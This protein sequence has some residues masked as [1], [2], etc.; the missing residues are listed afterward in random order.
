MIF[1][2]PS[3]GP[4]PKPARAIPD[5]SAPRDRSRTARQSVAAW[6]PTIL[7]A[8]GLKV[9]E[10]SSGE[11]IDLVRR[12]NQAVTQARARLEVLAAELGGC[13]DVGERLELARIRYFEYRVARDVGHLAVLLTRP[14]ATLLRASTPPVEEALAL[15]ERDALVLGGRLRRAYGRSS[16]SLSRD[17]GALVET[18]AMLV[19]WCRE[20]EELCWRCGVPVPD[21]LGAEKA[22]LYRVLDVGRHLS[23]VADTALVS[24]MEGDITRFEEA[25]TNAREAQCRWSAGSLADLHAFDDDRAFW[26]AMT[27]AFAGAPI[28][29]GGPLLESLWRQLDDR[30][31]GVLRCSRKVVDAHGDGDVCWSRSFFAQLHCAPVV[32]LALD[33]LHVVLAAA[34]GGPGTSSEI[35]Y[36]E[37]TGDQPTPLAALLTRVAEAERRRR[38]TELLRNDQLS[39]DREFRREQFGGY[40]PL[41][42]AGS[43]LAGNFL[44]NF[45]AFLARNWRC[46]TGAGGGW[47]RRRGW[48]TSCSTPRGSTS[49]PCVRSS[50]TSGRTASIRRSGPPRCWRTPAAPIRTRR[51]S[52]GEPYVRGCSTRC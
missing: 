23:D 21:G 30:R 24:T 41:V 5:E 36:H 39:A 28:V 20:I 16:T 14:S 13:P 11:E 34:G 2:D 48:W 15:D 7:R 18:A 1:L 49:T 38:V 4:R 47:T 32:D 51:P 31:D 52:S 46:T 8:L 26:Q 6:I 50:S 9:R 22:T 25:V 45:S 19:A 40:R 42:D 37:I 12:H 10:E 33:D 27:E 17:V 35:R 29:G 3:P 43:K 44:N